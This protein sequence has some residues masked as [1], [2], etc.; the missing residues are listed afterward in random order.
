MKTSIS[1]LVLSAALMASS[2]SADSF[3]K[4]QE[5]AIRDIVEKTLK[6]N[7]TLIVD[8]L[9][10]AAEKEQAKQKEVQSKTLATAKDKLFG[11]KAAPSVGKADGTNVITVFLDPYCGHCRDFHKP[12]EEA[13]KAVA[14]S[15]IIIKDLPIFGEPSILAVSALL[16]AHKQGKYMEFYRALSS[17]EKPLIKADL[18]KLAGKVG[19]DTAKLEKDMD[20]KDVK[21]M[22][23]A[24][25][26]LAQSLQINGTP[27]IV[28]STEV[29]PGGV[30]L[31]TL[32]GFLGKA[33]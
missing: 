10:A 30:D 1:L 12:M 27:G 7:P 8:T 22:I 19:I 5:T 33:A 24:N 26:D 13:V 31:E 11:D 4:D 20:S 2:V 28:T 21:D 16:G 17:T 15:K 14:N 23:A 18:I 29:I 6:E 3:S 32:K 9:K 25:R